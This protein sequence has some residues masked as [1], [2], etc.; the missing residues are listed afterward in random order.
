[1]SFKPKQ[2]SAVEMHHSNS[3][4][5]MEKSL[6]TR[7]G[8]QDISLQKHRIFHLKLE[9]GM[10]RVTMRKFNSK[11]LIFVKLENYLPRKNVEAHLL[12]TI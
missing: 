7:C 3:R 8:L 11:A 9:L 5:P 12:V 4:K 1:M 10:Y 6:N 2:L